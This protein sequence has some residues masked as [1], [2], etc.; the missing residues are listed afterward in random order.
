VAVKG[1]TES[2]GVGVIDLA[3]Q[4]EQWGVKEIIYTDIRRDGTLTGPDL[5]GLEKII[6][7]TNSAGY[8]VRRH[9]FCRR[10]NLS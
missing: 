4:I 7:K 6:N 2:S 9:I 3:A 1:W 10:F 5:E 8:Y